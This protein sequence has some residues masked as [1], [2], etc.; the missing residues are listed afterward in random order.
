MK[1]FVLLFLL[2]VTAISI[3]LACECGLEGSTSRIYRGSKV[4]PNKYPWLAYIRSY[5]DRK[6]GSYHRCGGSLIDERHIITAAHCVVNA[7][8]KV[9]SLSNL[10]VFLGLVKAFNVSSKPNSVSK[11]WIH[12]KYDTSDL[13][14]DLAILT[15]SKPV[16]YTQTVAPVCLPNFENGLSTLMVAGWGRTAANA[17]FTNDLLEVEVDYLTKKECN[18]LKKDYE[19]KLDGISDSMKSQVEVESVAETHMCAINKK[20]KGDSCSGDSGGPLMYQGDN[21]RYYLMGIVS[22]SWADCGEVEEI[23]GLYTRTFIYKNFIKSIATNACWQTK[24]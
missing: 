22:G 1:F 17:G 14:N 2:L 5:S 12:D 8:G 3:T 4:R 9:Y 10:D 11:V 13:S 7:N 16:K 24:H 23:A 15:L 21:G 20:T 19:M 6:N 18:D